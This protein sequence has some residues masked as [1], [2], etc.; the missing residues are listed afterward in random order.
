[1]FVLRLSKMDEP[2]PPNCLFSALAEPPAF[3]MCTPIC[4]IYLYTYFTCPYKIYIHAC[5]KIYESFFFSF[6]VKHFSATCGGAIA[7][8]TALYW[9]GG[10]DA[11]G[12]PGGGN[13]DRN[14]PGCP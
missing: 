7:E 9:W 11:S 12:I 14:S 8:I 1:M 3:P 6:L 13:V 10:E 4:V 2:L 5:L